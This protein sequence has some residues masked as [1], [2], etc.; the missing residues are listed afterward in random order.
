[1]RPTELHWYGSF[2]WRE[3]NEERRMAI[4]SC[5]IRTAIKQILLCWH[6][7]YT[8]KYFDRY[9]EFSNGNTAQA[10]T[11]STFII[12][13]AHCI[14]PK[15]LQTK[16]LPENVTALLGRFN[17]ASKTEQGSVHREVLLIQ[18]HEDWNSTSDK[19]DADLAILF[20]KESVEFSSYIKPI[21]LS[22]NRNIENIKDGVIVSSI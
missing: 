4:F 17:I 10:I 20:L 2:H 19:F 5:T 7:N 3:R 12:L 9:V 22:Y 13:A 11:S 18:V 1:M 6:N 21:C 15:Y 14:E 8:K 16:F